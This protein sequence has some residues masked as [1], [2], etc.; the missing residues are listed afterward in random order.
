MNGK[1][2]CNNTSQISGIPR[3]RVNSYKFLGVLLDEH[4]TWSDHIKYIKSKISKINGILTPVCHLT[5]KTTALMLH[6]SLIHPSLS[7]C[8]IVIFALYWQNYSSL[9]PLRTEQK[10]SLRI[11][12]IIYTYI[13]IIH[14]YIIYIIHH[15]KPHSSTKSWLTDSKILNIYQLNSFQTAVLLHKFS[16]SM[17]LPPFDNYNTSPFIRNSFPRLQSLSEWICKYHPETIFHEM[18]RSTYTFIHS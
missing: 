11:I 16:L 4:L 13:Y 2:G 6:Y 14:I 7:Y 9:K 5:D 1:I 15:L 17:L 18:F 3:Y 8:N 12:H 10:R